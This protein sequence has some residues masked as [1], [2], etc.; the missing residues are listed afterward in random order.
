M[1]D[2]KDYYETLGVSRDA[3]D[4]TIRKAF[5]KLSKKYHP[6]LNHAPGAEQ[7]FKDINEAYQVLSDP[8]KRAAYDQYGSADGPPRVWRRWCWSR[9]I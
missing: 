3:D 6:D 1:A 8:Q 5:R 9:R 2:Q 4:D 7:K